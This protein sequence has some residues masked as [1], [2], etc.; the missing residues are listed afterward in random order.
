MLND[1]HP[2]E[3]V[4]AEVGNI[5]SIEGLRGVAVILVVLFHYLVVRTPAAADPW[6]AFVSRHHALAVIVGNGYLGVDLFFLITG[7][8]LILPWA[9]HAYHGKPPPSAKDFY[10]R[11]IRRIVPA[12]YVQ[13]AVLLGVVMPILHGIDYWKRDI[14]FIGYNAVAHLLFLHYTT[15]IS[16]ASMSANGP[17][18][19]LTLEAQY[20][21][22]LPLFAGRFVRAPLR[23]GL[24]LVAAAIAWR[25]LALHDLGPLVRF[26]MALGAR[27]RLTEDIIR[28]LILTQLPGYLAHFALGILLG[29]AWL[30]MRTRNPRSIR[31]A[32]WS[33]VALAALAALYWLYGMGGGAWTG[34]WTW[35]VTALLI[36][37]ALF[38]TLVKGVR[39][40]DALLGRGPLRFVGRVSYSAYL[41][42][43]P[44]LVVWNEWRVLDGRWTSLP[45]YLAALGLLSWLSYR[46]VELPFMR[47]TRRSG[48]RTQTHGERREDGEDLQQGHAP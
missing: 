31:D 18:W 21:V 9:R 46:F 14:E 10:I 7:F 41:Y 3:G 12:Y 42:H 44:L 16:S 37:T 23:W 40:G 35:L 1:R 33:L 39:V 26:E 11:R 5:E 13:L 36:A 27:W 4:R 48:A 15:P 6:N 29:I 2:E 17:L 38:F 22:L 19:T 24:G 43:F 47:R 30:T 8:L 28:H 20:Y 45:A 34:T 25:W 32:R